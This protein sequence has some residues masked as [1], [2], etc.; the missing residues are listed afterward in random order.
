[1]GI[2]VILARILLFID[3]FFEI[4]RNKY[5]FF[6]L[7]S[8]IIFLF[9]FNFG[10]FWDNVLFTSKI[11]NHLYNNSIFDWM[12]PN[13]LDAGHPPTLGF[14]LA[15]FWK[16][17]GHKLWVSHLLMVP[18][19]I[20]FFY[21]LFQFIKFYTKSNLYSFFAF[22]LILV[23][24]TLSTQFVIVNPEI[25][26]LFLFFLAINSILHN[27]IQ[28]KTISLFF[29]SII[30]LRSMLLCGGV[31][32]FEILNRYYFNKRKESVLSKKL[33]FSYIIIGIPA[34]TY[35]LVHYISKGWL[36]SHVNSPWA[37]HRQFIS[38]DGFIKNILVLGH[39]YLDFGRFIICMLIVFVFIKYKKNVFDKKVVQLLLLSF[40]SVLLVII[41]SLL[42]ANPFGHRYFIVSYIVLNLLSFIFMIT[43]FRKKRVIYTLIFLTLL[44]GNLW[45]YPK[46]IAQGWDATLGHIPYHSLRIE[47]IDYLNNQ[48]IDITN[49]ASFFPNN[50]ALDNVDFSEDKRAFIS[51]NKKNKYAFYSNVYNLSDENLNILETNYS[52][53][54]QFKKNNI[55]VIIYIL[56]EK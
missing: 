37:D 33:I 28:L 19:T 16:I 20:G 2:K 36:V 23:D 11:G 34:I 53:L 52:I 3:V 5:L 7:L 51:F 40:S 32:L 13:N 15:I 43:F 18:F 26:Q 44:T 39:K 42:S 49:V 6:T 8:G 55:I 21:Q 24:P 54:K 12:L 1:M 30:S 22:L 35:L 4:R 47:A 38:F 45:V 31:F 46:K 29:L 10:M 9:S 17:F 14:L 50:T 41:I 48:K 27:R 56:N 25:I